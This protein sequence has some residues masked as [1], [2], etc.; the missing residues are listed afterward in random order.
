MK[1]ELPQTPIDGYEIKWFY[2]RDRW[3]MVNGRVTLVECSIW[4]SRLVYDA[5]DQVWTCYRNALAPERYQVECWGLPDQ[6]IQ[7][8][9]ELGRNKFATR[10][11]ALLSAKILL[12]KKIERL[13]TDLARAKKRFCEITEGLT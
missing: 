11:E 6:I 1:I 5:A 13:E 3:P 8:L 12:G 10:S 9:Y 4:E 2:V 7:E